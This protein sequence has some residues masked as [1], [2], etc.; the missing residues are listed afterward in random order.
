MINMN[1]MKTLQRYYNILCEK[2]GERRILGVFLYGSQNYNIATENSDV[3]A[4]A[5]YIPSLEEIARD[6]KPMSIEIPLEDGAHIEVK[7]IRLMC[8]AWKK[9]SV[10]FV[11]ILFTTY[12]VINSFYLFVWDEFCDLKEEIAHYNKYQT[13][14]SAYWSA[15]RMIDKDNVTAKQLVNARKYAYFLEQYINDKPYLECIYLPDGYAEDLKEMKR[16]G[17]SYYYKSLEVNTAHCKLNEMYDYAET[18]A[19]ELNKPNAAV[20]EAMTKITMLALTRGF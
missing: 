8:K 9:Q 20:D 15:K 10:N 7:D 6:E 4:K 17:G 12:A 5:I 1:E 16:N 2:Y 3:D 11:E 19:A 14:I 13:I 18:H